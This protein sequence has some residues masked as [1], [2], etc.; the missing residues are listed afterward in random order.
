MKRYFFTSILILIIFSFVFAAEEVVD[1][2]S[3]S[4]FSSF[5]EISSEKYL[6]QS[7]TGNG[8]NL[9]SAK[10][11][12]K[13]SSSATGNMHAELYAHSG[14]YGSTSV[15]TGSPLAV[16]SSKLAST[17][18]TSYDLCSF[19]FD[20]TYTLVDGTYYVIVIYYDGT[21]G[22]PGYLY[23]SLDNTSLTH[24]G[25]ACG[26]NDGSTWYDQTNYWGTPVDLIFY[27][28]GESAVS[29]AGQVIII[30]D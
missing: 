11:Y 15:A 28:Y 30:G 17:L 19:T 20:G 25:S 3:E 21:G 6:G 5:F 22:S 7:F 1:S 8:K 29:G 18:T 24:S 12:L 10:F 9:S 27:V 4:N 13:K 2:Y 26:S 14:T 16:S 23:V